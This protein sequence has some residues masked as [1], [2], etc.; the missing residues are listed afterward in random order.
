MLCTVHKAAGS[1]AKHG[2]I[3]GCP[4]RATKQSLSPTFCRISV[5]VS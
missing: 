5:G 4:L 2:L 1:S 3:V